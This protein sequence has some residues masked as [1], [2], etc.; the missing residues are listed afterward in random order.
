MQVTHYKGIVLFC[1]RGGKFGPSRNYNSFL[2]ILGKTLEAGGDVEL[3]LH[4]IEV[5]PNDT[6]LSKRLEYEALRKTY[7]VGS[8]IQRADMILYTPRGD[9]AT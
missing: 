5:V 3:E 6:L 8:R 4:P 7:G 2:K 1:D 9:N